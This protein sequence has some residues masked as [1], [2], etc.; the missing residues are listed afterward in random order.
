MLSI[1]CSVLVHAAQSFKLCSAQFS[2]EAETPPPGNHCS[3]H[4]DLVWSR[5]LRGSVFPILP[6][7]FAPC[8]CLVPGGG[9]DACEETKVCPALGV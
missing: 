1:S 8:L 7:I 4:F 5:L 3:S 9:S 2:R 6:F